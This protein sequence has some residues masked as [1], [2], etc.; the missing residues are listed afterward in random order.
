MSPVLG[1]ISI[2]IISEVITCNIVVSFVVFVTVN[3]FHP[4]LT[5]ASKAG[6]YLS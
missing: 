5:F 6:A 1:V 3:H 2:V 4:S